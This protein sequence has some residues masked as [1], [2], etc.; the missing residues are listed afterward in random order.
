MP[1]APGSLNRATMSVALATVLD[2][3]TSSQ[4]SPYGSAR[5]LPS[6]QELK[7]Q[8][9]SSRCSVS[10]CRRASGTSSR[11]C[12]ANIDELFRSRARSIQAVRKRLIEAGVEIRTRLRVLADEDL[13]ATRAAMDH[14]SGVRDIAHGLG[15]ADTAVTRSWHVV[16]KRRI[17]HCSPSRKFA[18]TRVNMKSKPAS[19]SKC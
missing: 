6:V 18:L 2:M 12:S 7:Q 14:G 13:Q 5:D 15:V 9:A 11:T 19:A 3:A 4:V 16:M 1:E 17:H 10:C 8:M